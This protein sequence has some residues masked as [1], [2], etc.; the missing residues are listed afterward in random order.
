MKK[1]NDQAELLFAIRFERQDEFNK[2]E[3]GGSLSCDRIAMLG[4]LT[5][6]KATPRQQTAAE[7][8]QR[9]NKKDKPP[10]QG[11]VVVQWQLAARGEEGRK[12]EISKK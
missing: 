4:A 5:D 9:E 3:K 6:T 10:R 2:A 8:E 12:D 7:A 1:K 11:V